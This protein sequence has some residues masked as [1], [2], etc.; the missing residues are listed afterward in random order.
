MQAEGWTNEETARSRS[1]EMESS[2]VEIKRLMA[3]RRN[4]A[5][6]DKQQLM[7]VSKRIKKCI[8]NKKRAK[9]KEAIQHILEQFSG[10]KNMSQI[11]FA[12]KKS[13]IPKMKN[14]KR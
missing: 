1:K 11:K 14:E 2:D 3:E 8:R 5:R 6:E 12:K 10:I 4:F 9:R 13:L 7:E